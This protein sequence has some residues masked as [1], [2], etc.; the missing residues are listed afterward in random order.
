MIFEAI[1]KYDGVMERSLSTSQIKQIA[2]RAGR[3]GLHEG[4]VPQGYVTTLFHRDLHILRDA[5]A[6]APQP[7]TH[8]HIS[9]RPDIIS[10][11]SQALPSDA[12]TL[13]IYEA[14]VYL[15]KMRPVYRP[16]EFNHLNDR[17]RFLDQLAGSLT[18]DDRD[19][20]MKSPIPWRNALALR[21]V[22]N[23]MRM[24][25]DEMR[26]RLSQA[27]RGTPLMVTLATVEKLMGA[28]VPPANIH[29]L[30]VLE[31]F[32]KV[33]VLYLWLSM[34][35][36]VIFP[37]YD[38]A[39]NV[40]LRVEKVL[41]WCLQTL[42]WDTRQSNPKKP[43]ATSKIH[44]KFPKRFGRPPGNQPVGIRVDHLDLSRDTARQ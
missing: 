26:V 2:G 39:T 37:E 10:H 27:L 18:L 6:A 3:Y 17:C 7:L 13:T 11:I 16:E 43:R 5:M 22:A 9:A 33:L 15:S 24:Y 1:R 32:H 23:I 28:A 34:R 41:H 36:P 42:K 12:S 20:L 35:N 40:K 19:L 38:E 8:A 25:R 29:N 14:Y 21:A 4:D 31:T 44:A 30:D